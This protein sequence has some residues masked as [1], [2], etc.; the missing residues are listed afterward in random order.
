[1]QSKPCSQVSIDGT[2]S[3]CIAKESTMKLRIALTAALA[4]ALAAFAVFAVIA[5]RAAADGQDVMLRAKLSGLAQVPPIKTAATGTLR[6]TLDEAKQQIAFTLEYRNL[7]ASPTMAH[8]HFGPTK[9]NGGVVAF[10]CGGGG[11]PACPAATTGKITGN[12]T[13]ANVVA[14]EAQG[15]KAN[16]FAGLVYAIRTGNAYVNIHNAAYPDGEPRGQIATS[17]AGRAEQ[18]DGSDD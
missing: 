3:R 13:A 6:A 16:D 9:V 7:T 17:G 1:M 12:I 2:A 11:Q 18:P 14:L 10:F 15:I 5:H 4:L 8:I